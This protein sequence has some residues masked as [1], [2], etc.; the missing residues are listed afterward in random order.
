MN[1]SYKTNENKTADDLTPH[2]DKSLESEKSRN[3]S[4][5]S[6]KE[7][8]M[9]LGKLNIYCNKQEIRALDEMTP[10]FLKEFLPAY[11]PEGS[12]SQGKALVWT[13]REFL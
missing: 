12:V 5:R 11:N 3:L 4:D 6:I 10:A 1:T 13:L 9:H 2:I 7:L 8:G